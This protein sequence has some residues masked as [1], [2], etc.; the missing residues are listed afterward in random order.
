MKKIV[1][2]LLPTL[3]FGQKIETL[4]LLSPIND[5]SKTI[6]SLIV[7]DERPD[8]DLGTISFR[9]KTY[10]FE[11]PNNNSKTSL[12]EWFLKSNKK[13]SGEKDVVLFIEN[14]K[15]LSEGGRK[16]CCIIYR[17]YKSVERGRRKVTDTKSSFKNKHLYI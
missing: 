9:D 14:I 2:F 4:Q 15:V 13:A 1:L 8:K 16:R 11:F 7:M 6:K 10:H 5:N 3:I 17:K 12:E